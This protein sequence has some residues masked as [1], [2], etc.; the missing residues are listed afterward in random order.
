MEHLYGM[1]TFKFLVEKF[2][3]KNS[4]INEHLASEINN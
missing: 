2:K 4:K 3:A 1:L